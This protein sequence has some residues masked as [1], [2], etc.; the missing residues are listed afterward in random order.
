[1]QKVQAVS[2]QIPVFLDMDG[3]TDDLVSL[4]ILMTLPNFRLTGVSI[5]NG[6]CY[7]KNALE[8]VLRIYGLFGRNDLEV[9]VSDAKAV[10]VFPT[11]WREKGKLINNLD[12]IKDITPDYS[13]ASK[14]EASEFTA[15]KILSQEGKSII[16]LTG[17]AANLSNTIEKYP[18]I[19]EKIEKVYWMAGAFLSNGNVI[20][21]DH[22]GSAEW[23]IFWDPISARKLI[24]SDLKIVLIPLDACYQVPVDN[25]LM[26]FLKKQSKKHKLSR[27]VYNML[28]LNYKDHSKYFIWDVLPSLILGFPEIAHMS[29]TSIDIELR[30]TSFGNI[31]K[32]SKGSPIHYAS[33]IDDEKFYESFFHQLKQL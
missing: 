6:N 27:L 28:E 33:L 24:T 31:F 25:Y 10:N 11:K 5:T 32:T 20:A 8:S 14:V 17:P 2:D 12:V 18:E 19:I 22:D 23:N 9:A 30:G 3:A 21:P 4:I 16:I 26:Y 29:N 15:Q 7:L 13:K 1:M